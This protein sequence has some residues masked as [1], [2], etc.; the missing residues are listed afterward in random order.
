MAITS[1][2]LCEPQPGE[3][4]HNPVSRQFVTLPAYLGWIRFMT[5]FYMPVSAQMAEATEKW[6]ESE[7]P[8]ETAVNLAM[9]TPLSAFTF[10]T[11]SRE[12]NKLFGG[13]MKGVAASEGT[14][15]RHLL[16]DYDWAQLNQGLVV[17]VSL[18]LIRVERSWK[19]LTNGKID[20]R[21][22]RNRLR[23]AGR[24]LPSTAI[25]GARHRRADQPEP[26]VFEVAARANPLGDRYNRLR[27]L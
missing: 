5:D 18:F 27:P 17:H 19:N 24:G 15:V 22:P 13:Y 8:T 23:G 4:A 1:G 12:F 3:I 7:Q 9:N 6:G 16:E 26:L 2:C 14:A 20:R 25:R 11:R 21:C 10:I